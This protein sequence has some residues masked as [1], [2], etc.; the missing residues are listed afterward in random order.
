MLKETLNSFRLDYIDLY[1]IHWPFGFKVG[2]SY[3]PLGDGPHTY[4]DIDYIE[5]WEAMEDCVKQG[6]TKSIGVSN[7]NSEQIDRLLKFAKIKPVVNQVETNPNINQKKLIQF[8]KGRDIVLTGY[9]PLGRND[10][11]GI[12]GLPVPSILDPKVK[13]IGEKYS[14]TPAQVVLNYL[15][16]IFIIGL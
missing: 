3:W 16:I 1:L 9:C 11:V 15:V 7:F 14:K 8:C 6:L 5:T 10:S 13:K 4:S 2:T 12:P